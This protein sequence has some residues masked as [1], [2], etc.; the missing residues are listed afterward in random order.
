MKSL[1]ASHDHYTN[2][3]EDLQSRG[4]NLNRRIADL[5]EVST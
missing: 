5:E 3:C 4:S 1:Q 2:E